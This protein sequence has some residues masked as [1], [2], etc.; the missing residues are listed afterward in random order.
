[1]VVTKGALVTTDDGKL[2]R[3]LG[4]LP[5]SIFDPSD[6]DEESLQRAG[7]QVATSIPSTFDSSAA[8]CTTRSSKSSLKPQR[9][10][11]A[12]DF[13]PQLSVTVPPNSTRSRASRS[14]QTD[15]ATGQAVRSLIGS[16]ARSDT[17]ATS[18]SDSLGPSQPSSVSGSQ[19]QLSRKVF[20]DSGPSY[21]SLAQ[22]KTCMT[23]IRKVGEQVFENEHD[24]NEEKINFAFSLKPIDTALAATIEETNDVVVRRI[25]RRWLIYLMDWLEACLRK[26]NR[27]LVYARICGQET[28]LTSRKRKAAKKPREDDAVDDRYNIKCRCHFPWKSEDVGD[29]LD[30]R[31]HER[32][33]EHIKHC[34][35]SHV[36]E[37]QAFFREQGEKEVMNRRFRQRRWR[38]N[39]AKPPKTLDK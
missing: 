28:R 23:Y 12:T 3:Q 38:K 36:A 5:A 4:Y 39:R 8:T 13:V 16:A 24:G 34:I 7:P 26:E 18:T 1:M 35:I 30:D 25:M 14:S 15:R 20:V 6:S 29:E 33:V 17:L 11:C 2:V 37:N 22:L 9:K 31:L 10:R 19:S 21:V 32:I 27:S